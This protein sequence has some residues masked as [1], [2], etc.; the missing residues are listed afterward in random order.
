MTRRSPF[1]RHVIALAVASALCVPPAFAR[2]PH[3]A[4]PEQSAAEKAMQKLHT[5]SGAKQE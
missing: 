3:A 1:A 5:R 2:E 4:G